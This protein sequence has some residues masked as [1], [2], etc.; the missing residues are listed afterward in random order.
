[1]HRHFACILLLAAVAL[2]TAV[3]A[4]SGDVARWTQTASPCWQDLLAS[5]AL[6]PIDRVPVGCEIVDCCPGCPLAS[7]LDWRVQVSG[8]AVEAVDISFDNL[9]SAHLQGLVLRQKAERAE[10]SI[11]IRKGTGIVRGLPLV[12]TGAPP[13][14]NMK[15]R[16]NA[17]WQP[18]AGAATPL[19]IRL[20]QLLGNVV[21]NEFALRF[22]VRPCPVAQSAPSDDGIQL[23]NNIA[24]DSAVVLLRARRTSPADCDPIE[25]VRTTNSTSVGSVKSNLA[26]KSDIAVFSDDNAMAYVPV[27][28][29]PDNPAWTDNPGDQVPIALKPRLMQNVTLWLVRDASE[30][31]A[32]LAVDTANERYNSN[33]VGIGFNVTIKDV[34]EHES[35]IGLADCVRTEA[36][37]EAWENGPFYVKNQVNVYYLN[38]TT[39]P[40]TCSPS[41]KPDM[42]YVGSTSDDSTLAHEFGHTLMLEDRLQGSWHADNIMREAS[43]VRT[44][45]FEGQAFRMNMHC[46]STINTN[47]VRPAGSPLKSCKDTVDGENACPVDHNCPDVEHNVEIK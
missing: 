8:N 11:R 31:T 6:F 44:L 22:D 10:N 18:Q 16:L 30:T 39:T 32:L 9:S 24:N 34:S 20:E 46:T 12:A 36:E 17:D 7:A 42:V 1:M 28:T 47:G 37:W 19:Q 45:V 27:G 3:G 41:G 15:L 23:T 21:V 33:N 43:T 4:K 2:S 5:P 35:E 38:S 25:D 13:V 26:C 14:A 29:P 40:A